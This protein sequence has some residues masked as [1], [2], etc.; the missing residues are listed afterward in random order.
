MPV[1]E[2]PLR[3]VIRVTSAGAA[4]DDLLTER[5][6]RGELWRIN[7]IAW[8]D[9]TTAFTEGRTFVSGHG[10]NHWL[11]EQDS[12]VATTLYWDDEEYLLGENE[13]VGVRMT[14]ATSG[15]LLR[16]YI[17][18]FRL[19]EDSA[20]PHMSGHLPEEDQPDA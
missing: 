10:Y 18:G 16:L 9:E 14:G 15:D 17:D 4:F 12:P 13:Q 5:V 2:R 6:P 8:E 19:V 11:K 1:L 3:L 7:H 20:P